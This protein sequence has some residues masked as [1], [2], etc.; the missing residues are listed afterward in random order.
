MRQAANRIAS[1]L[2]LELLGSD[3]DAGRRRVSDASYTADA[4]GRR[5]AEAAGSGEWTVQ[6]E[7]VKLLNDYLGQVTLQID[8]GND[9]QATRTITA[10]QPLIDGMSIEDDLQ[11]ELSGAGEIIRG[12]AGHI[13]RISYRH[14]TRCAAE[15]CPP[16][17]IAAHLGRC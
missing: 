12:L 2:Q 3:L 7:D 17:L 5:V 14:L 4:A 11:M 10:L 9:E 6:P 16:H 13:A 15:F 1:T 8:V